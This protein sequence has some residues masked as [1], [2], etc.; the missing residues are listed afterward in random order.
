VIDS[1]VWG[2]TLGGVTSSVLAM[3]NTCIQEA[4]AGA[5]TGNFTGDPKFIG[6]WYLSKNGLSMQTADSPCRDAGTVT[7]TARGLADRTTLTDGTVDSGASQVDLGYHYIGAFAENL[8]NLVL[9]VDIVKGS[10]ANTGWASGAG[11]ALKHISA[12]LAR[13]LDRTVIHVAT[14]TYNTANGETL[15][16][17]PRDAHLTVRGTNMPATV[18]NGGATKRGVKVMGRGRFRLEN[19]V[20]TNCLADN[21]RGGGL[22]VVGSDMTATNVWFTK[23][24]NKSYADPGNADAGLQVC[25]IGG[26]LTLVGCDVDNAGKASGESPYG[27]KG[28][29]I[30]AENAS[31]RLVRTRVRRNAFASN[32]G[33]F[34]I[35]VHMAGGDGWLEGCL[36]ETNMFSNAVAANRGAAI[37]AS[38]SAPLVVSNC[39]FVGNCGGG[40]RGTLYVAGSGLLACINRCVLSNNYVSGFSDSIFSDGAGN[41]RLVNTI[42]ARGAG[43]GISKEGVAGTLTMTNCLVYRQSNHAVRIT[44]G[45]V[46]VGG[47]TFAVNSGWGVTNS[48]GTVVV[49]NSIAWGN[50]AG[51]FGANMAVT[52]SDSQNAVA[53]AGNKNANPMFKSVAG[54]NYRLQRKSPC[55]NA[56]LNETWMKLAADLDGKTR[57]QDGVVDMGCYE[58]QHFSGTCLQV[59]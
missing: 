22:Y 25:V 48:A 17:E 58:D 52:Y 44:G 59:R 20:V 24:T 37:Y 18:V 28:V 34:G 47:C 31:L 50:T 13:A 35:G 1:I 53:G 40:G 49:K 19:M 29:G 15:P 21:M 41:T 9:Y 27:K 6:G 12:A 23:N 2:S 5:G 45:T 14:G 57:K 10:D 56:G 8:T 7:A 3:T 42:V 33:A 11:N 39:V 4:H 54:N 36:F 43:Y 38:G 16:I 26:R 55:V 32:N 46:S 51:G 30:Y